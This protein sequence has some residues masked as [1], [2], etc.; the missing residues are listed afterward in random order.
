ML[1]SDKE[2][3]NLPEKSVI[4]N[5]FKS[6]YYASRGVYVGFS[7]EPNLLLQTAIGILSALI[8]IYNNLYLL[9]LVDIVMMFFTLS[10]EFLNTAIETLCDLVHPT[11]SL[12]VKIIKDLA[13]AGVWMI[14]LAWLVFLIYS[15]YQVLN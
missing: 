11:F 9:A 7:R 2:I 3:K 5:P 1:E 14:A 12:K 4:Y 6:V 10:S 13:A 15:G 8:L